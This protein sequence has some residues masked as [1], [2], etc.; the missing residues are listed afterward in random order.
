MV[1]DGHSVFVLRANTRDEAI[2]EANAACTEQGAVAVFHGFMQYRAYRIRTHSAWFE[3][4][5]RL[6]TS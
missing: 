4:V 2:P 5:P 1:V 3:C 6:G